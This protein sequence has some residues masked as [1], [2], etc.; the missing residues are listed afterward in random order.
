MKVNPR[1]VFFVLGVAAIAGGIGGLSAAL[2]AGGVAAVIIS[3][4]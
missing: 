2:I 1:T 3:L 4:L